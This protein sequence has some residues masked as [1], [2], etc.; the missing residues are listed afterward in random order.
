MLRQVI[1]FT[2]EEAWLSNRVHD[3]TSSDI[4]TLFG[5]GY[6]TYGQ[7]LEAK[8][9]KLE[10][11]IEPNERMDWGTA[12]EPAIAGE[13][14][15]RN[16]WTIRRKKEYIRLPELRI[17]SSFDYEI[18]GEDEDEKGEAHSVRY[19]MEVKN[20]GMDAYSRDWIK[21]FQIEAPPRIEL[22]IQNE[23]LVSGL[24]KCYLC[25]LVGG[26]QGICLE[27]THNLKIQQ[28]ILSKAK[29]FWRVVDEAKT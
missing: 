29:E 20:V 11:K 6:S 10:L 18:E 12:L 22:Q 26:N 8:K 14:A 17:G 23:L 13:F 1:P 2:I 5:C 16:N 21:G 3:L 24:S 25:V 15:R 7:L 9:L 4:A 28:A 27:R 19:L